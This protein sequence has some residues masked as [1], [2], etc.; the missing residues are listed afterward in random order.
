MTLEKE[1]VVL[2]YQLWIPLLDYVN[3]KYQ[4]HPEWKKIEQGPGFDQMA[5]KKI[6]DY[7]WAHTQVLD[8]YLAQAKLPE[9]QA[10]I[11]ASWKRCRPGKYV[12]ER[13]LK[14]GT[15]FISE[16]DQTVYMVKGLASTWEEMLGKGPVLMDAVLIPFR[17]SIISDGLVVPYPVYFGGGVSDAFKEIY[18]NAKKNGT[19][20]FSLTGEAPE[21]PQK[22]ETNKAESYVIKAALGAGCYRHIRI[23]NQETLDTLAEAIL[24]AFDFDNDHLH[25]FFMDDRYWSEDDAYYS[26]DMDED[27]RL[28][29]EV[30]LRQLKLKKGDRFKFLFDFG[31]EWGFQCRVLQELEEKTKIPSVIKSVGEAPEQY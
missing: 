16:D 31:D 17:D 27:C 8:E 28:S 14:K 15:V 6:A 20:R 7:L 25:A 19:I 11:V 3:Q 22:K 23:G 30:T 12:M 18:M 5:A 2:F 4:V 24:S 21:R 10:Q 26:H 13:H 29:C 9:E 1:D